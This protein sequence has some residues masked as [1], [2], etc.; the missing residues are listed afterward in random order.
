MSSVRIETIPA[1]SFQQTERVM[2]P[3]GNVDYLYGDVKVILRRAGGRRH[4]TGRSHFGAT[5]FAGLLV[6]APVEGSVTLRTV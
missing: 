6:L 3:S 2:A 1:R 4:C 5:H